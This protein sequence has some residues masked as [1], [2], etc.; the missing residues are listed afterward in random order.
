MLGN[1]FDGKLTGIKKRRQSGFFVFV[2]LILFVSGTLHGQAPLPVEVNDMLILLADTKLPPLRVTEVSTG[3]K[4]NLSELSVNDLTHPGKPSAII[5]WNSK[6]DFDAKF[7]N[8]F[9]EQQ[10]QKDYNIIFL[11]AATENNPSL[12]DPA[13]SAEILADTRKIVSAQKFRDKTLHLI[14]NQG[15]FR[16]YFPGDKTPFVIFVDQ[17]FLIADIY[18]S[19]FY[20]M[21][22]RDRLSQ[23]VSGNRLYSD[24][25]FFFDT[26]ILTS[27]EKARKYGMK[28]K[29][30]NVLSVKYVSVKDDL[31]LREQSYRLDN[32]KITSDGPFKKYHK[33]GKVESQGIAKNNEIIVYEA[34]SIEGNRI[35]EYNVPAVGNG[36]AKSWRENGVPETENSFINGKVTGLQKTFDESGS[37]ASEVMATDGSRDGPEKLYKAGKLIAE[38]IFS[39][40]E[41]KSG[42]VEKPDFVFYPYKNGMARVCLNGKFGVMDEKG[43][44]IAPPFYDKIG[45]F[46][47]GIAPV[48][49][50][51]KMNEVYEFVGGAWGYIDENG[52]LVV[53]PQYNSVE[54]FSEGLGLVGN[55]EHFGFIDKAGNVIVEGIYVAA[56]PFRNGVAI[57]CKEENKC[58][59]IDKTGKEVVPFKYHTINAF[60]EGLADV[61]LSET[62]KFGYI[63]VT[64]K[65]VTD[66]KY[67]FAG[68]IT[69]GMGLVEVNKKFGYIDRSGKEVI[70][71]KFTGGRFFHEGLAVVE[72]EGKKG[73]IDKSGTLMMW[74]K[75][76][77]L[78]DF[79]EGLAAVCLD[80]RFGY[81][82]RDG[83]TIVPHQYDR[84]FQF[85]QG[86]AAVKKDGKIGFIDNKG[87][88]VI[89]PDYEWASEKGFQDGF[90]DVLKDRTLYTI[91]KAGR[92]VSSWPAEKYR[93]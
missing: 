29:T 1:Y 83:K 86:L 84:A 11:N 45:G 64:G 5:C 19:N 6:N 44:L 91:D 26:R 58:G 79:S 55:G 43:N 76:S 74:G 69:E 71:M 38:M 73:F 52:K 33:N 77:C 87:K 7:V 17:N 20:T 92:I 39:K 27:K 78:D 35:R 24:N 23:L 90:I 46:H 40:G 75:Y 63:D 8:E 18:S 36:Y 13:G 50:G 28:M 47:E 81:V 42:R 30:G 68:D 59:L 31:P 2:F 48:N 3:K 10:V 57:V 4:T 65:M 41:M 82:D 37:L 89:S 93:R 49:I 72:A 21:E 22:I 16:Q 14:A 25:K 53:P 80:G 70:P 88:V 9:L 12:H 60:S 85:K 62:G 56:K 61:R 32:G 54:P 51:G 66:F 34:W 67:D 15:E